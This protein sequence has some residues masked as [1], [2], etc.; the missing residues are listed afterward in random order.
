MLC[1]SVYYKRTKTIKLVIIACI[2]SVQHTTSI[3][4][5]NVAMF[6][7]QR[8]TSFTSIVIVGVFSNSV[9][10]I[11]NNVIALISH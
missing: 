1:T 5:C 8:M 6:A 2:R 3:R 9:A 7:L 4:V 11:D 10:I